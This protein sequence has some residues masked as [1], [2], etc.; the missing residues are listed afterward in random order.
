MKKTVF[1]LL[2]ISILFGCNNDKKIEFKENQTEKIKPFKREFIVDIS[3]KTNTQGEIKIM[4]NDIVRDE[5]QKSN[6]HIFE[7]VIPTSTFDNF[8][9]NFGK[10]NISNNIFL[11]FG[12]KGEK[13]IDI[14]YINISFGD[15]EVNILPENLKTYFTFNKYIKYDS[16]NKKLVTFKNE[17]TH[18]PTLI[19]NRNIIQ[20]LIRVKSINK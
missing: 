16:I 7:S 11:N 1:I 10:N 15:N 17:N 20:E 5:F 14:N 4:M 8:T 19:L 18:N 6:I 3:F 12:S 9:A 13:I 2:I